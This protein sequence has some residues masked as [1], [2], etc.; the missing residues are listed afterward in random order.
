MAS[1]GYVSVPPSATRLQSPPRASSPLQRAKKVTTSLPTPPAAPP[2][3]T[4]S[5]PMPAH[6]LTSPTSAAFALLPQMLLSNAIPA[7][8]PP[9]VKDAARKGPQLLTTKEPLSLPITTAN[10]KRFVAKSGPIFWLQDRV[11]EVVLW[12]RGWRVTAVWMAVYAFLCAFPR[13][14]FAVPHVALIAVMLAPHPP[15]AMETSSPDWQGNLQAIQNLMGFVADAHD[16]IQPHTHLLRLNPASPRPQLLLLALLLTFPPLVVLLA[17]PLFPTR[18]VCLV[19]GLAPVLAAHPRIQPLLRPLAALAQAVAQNS[20]ILLVARYAAFLAWWTPTDASHGATTVPPLPTLLERLTDNDRLDDTCWRAEMREV[21]LW[22]NERFVPRPHPPA[23]VDDAAPPPSPAAF[24]SLPPDSPFNKNAHRL[25]GS[26]SLPLVA[27][28]PADPG[29]S[30]ANLRSGERRA[31]TRGQDGWG[32]I[33]SRSSFGSGSGS[34][35]GAD[36]EQHQSQREK[37]SAEREKEESDDGAVSSNLTF[38]LAPGWAFVRT[39]GWRRDLVR[40][41][42]A[43]PL[44]HADADADTHGDTHGDGWVYTNDAWSGAG[45]RGTPFPGCVTRRRRWVRRV[46]FDGEGAAGEGVA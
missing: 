38:S 34:G 42:A 7:T 36:E 2:S 26:V 32:G 8:P 45:A 44:A 10:F 37:E 13:M 23:A 33:R 22:E 46:W 39:E 6:G 4:S 9:A 17:S 29:W 5:P 27:P 12:K 1:L 24:A 15:K 43:L 40:A 25:S 20:L 21:E 18:S 31:W 41:W 35:A 3:S 30:K 11:E 28:G 19:A 16:L 14:V